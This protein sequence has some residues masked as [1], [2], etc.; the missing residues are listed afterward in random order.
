MEMPTSGA[1]NDLSFKGYLKPVAAN[2]AIASV[3]ANTSY[4]TS[5]SSGS[6]RLP[7]TDFKSPLISWKS[8]TDR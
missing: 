2:S 5:D 1:E 7:K 4:S 3:S 8:F 6:S